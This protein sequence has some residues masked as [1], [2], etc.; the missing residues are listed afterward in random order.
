MK[1]ISN[2]HFKLKIHKAVL[3]GNFE[4]V[5]LL[6]KQ[7]NVVNSLDGNKNTPLH[8]AMVEPHMKI[9]QFL[10]EN[11]ADPN[12]KNTRKMTPLHLV[13][14][15]KNGLAVVRLLLAAGAK[16]NR[17]DIYGNTPLH[18]AARYGNKDILEELLKAGANVAAMND[19]FQTPLSVAKRFA[20]INCSAILEDY[21]AVAE[22]T[23]FEIIKFSFKT[24]SPLKKI[25]LIAFSAFTL[26]IT[27]TIS[28][29]TSGAAAVSVL[30]ASLAILGMSL[31]LLGKQYFKI[32][33]LEKQLMNGD[34]TL[35]QF[36]EA[37]YSGKGD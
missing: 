19:E 9:I 3:N 15:K 34:I 29:L 8:V 7:Q 25:L 20:H 2:N 14:C 5:K 13:A 28:V 6:L 12:I 31:L 4:A 30:M 33:V 23:S 17:A 27:L 37:S 11:R 35:K 18:L 16:T 1:N 10:L 32:R 24:L 21:G 36:L 22:S 26:G